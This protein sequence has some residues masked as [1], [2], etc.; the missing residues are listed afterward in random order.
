MSVKKSMSEKFNAEKNKEKKA[1]EANEREALKKTAKEKAEKAKTSYCASD[2]EATSDTGS[3]SEDTQRDSTEQSDTE[4]KATK[5]PK[6]TRDNKKLAFYSRIE[7]AAHLMLAQKHL[8][9]DIISLVNA[10]F[11]DYTGKKFDKKECCRTRWMLKHNAVPGIEKDAAHYE[12][13]IEREGKLFN[14]LDAPK[15]KRSPKFTE[16]NDPLSTIAGM[17][18]HDYDEGKK[19]KKSKVK[20]EKVSE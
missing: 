17:D 10:K 11:P 7:Y 4:K 19:V 20:K 6:A 18:V 5:K 14:R 8:E 1:K 12:R 2:E 9:N 3:A 16:E 13:M 15:A